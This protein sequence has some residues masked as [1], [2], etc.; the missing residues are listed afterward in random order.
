MHSHYGITFDGAG[1]WSVNDGT[2]K[3]VIIFGAD[4]SS[5]SPSDNHRNNF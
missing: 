1:S 5:S 2:A 4:N 3:N